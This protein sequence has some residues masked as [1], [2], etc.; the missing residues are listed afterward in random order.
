[1][2]YWQAR[3]S[4]AAEASSWDGQGRSSFSLGP[5]VTGGGGVGGGGVGLWIS[6]RRGG[7]AAVPSAGRAQHVMGTMPVLMGSSR[8]A[9]AGEPLR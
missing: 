2:V 4:Q 7:S 9:P 3:D 1:M 5:T 6:R 8:R